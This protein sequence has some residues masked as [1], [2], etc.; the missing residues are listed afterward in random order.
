MEVGER[1][2]ADERGER[3]LGVKKRRQRR[4]ERVKER[5]E[6]R[7]V[8]NKGMGRRE[9]ENKVKGRRDGK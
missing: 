9:T 8:A 1:G 2:K 5:T 3:G 7:A 6:E 4:E